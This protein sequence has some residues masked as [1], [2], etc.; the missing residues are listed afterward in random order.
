M[1]RRRDIRSARVAEVADDGRTLVVRAVTYNVVDD[2]GTLFPP[3]VFAD[4]LGRRMPAFAWSH[5]WTEPI[6]RAT[7][8][9]E[10]PDG[11]YLTLRLSDPEAVPRARQAM[12][13]FA[14]GTLTDVSI[15][16]SGATWRPATDDELRTYPGV[17][18]VLTP[19]A[20]LDEVSAVLR[21]AVPGAELVLQRSADGAVSV[22]AVVELA[23][24]VAA[25]ELTQDEAGIALT[26]LGAG[27]TSTEGDDAGEPEG[28]GEDP[29]PVEF[30]GGEA[31]EAWLSPSRSRR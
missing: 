12:V 17:R 11:L 13:Q 6:G 15:G 26:L 28:G 31:L 16:F 2:Y 1:N 22:D 18:D 3:G 21:G 7:A 23:R 24:R 19:G 5:Q 30:D 10:R 9:E 25:G 14:E 4:S 20:D 27:E 8:A 29:A